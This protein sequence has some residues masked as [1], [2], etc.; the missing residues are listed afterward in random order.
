MSHPLLDIH[1]WHS[2]VDELNGFGMA[3]G[4]RP[5]VKDFPIRATNLLSVRQDVEGITHPASKQR[6]TCSSGLDS[7][8]EIAFGVVLVGVRCRDPRDMGLDQEGYLIGDWHFVAEHFGFLNIPTQKPSTLSP[9]QA[10][11][12]AQIEHIGDAPS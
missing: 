4:M 5:K 1:Q 10:G 2:I 7:R 3:K 12:V 11:I 9:L 8:K 6:A